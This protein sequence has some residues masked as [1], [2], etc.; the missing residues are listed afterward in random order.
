MERRKELLQARGTTSRESSIPSSSPRHTGTTASAL[1]VDINTIMAILRVVRSVE[2]ADLAVIFRKAK[3]G[4]P[5]DNLTFEVEKPI[6]ANKMG[7][8]QELGYLPFI[9]TLDDRDGYQFCALPAP[10]V[11]PLE[12]SI[13]TANFTCL[14]T[15]RSPG[16]GQGLRG[17]AKRTQEIAMNCDIRYHEYGGKMVELSFIK[18]LRTYYCNKHMSRRSLPPM[19]IYDPKGN[20]KV[21][22]ALYNGT[23]SKR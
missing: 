11:V 16:R 9:M 15:P 3:H 23:D 1:G 21:L 20:T 7:I 22:L 6:E 18:K 13:P 8:D 14:L 12:V 17:E 2:V 19:D 4:N 10:A 5:S